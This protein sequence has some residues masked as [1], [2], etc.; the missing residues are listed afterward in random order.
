M[1]NPAGAAFVGGGFVAYL[2]LLAVR[3]NPNIN[4]IAVASRTQEMAEHRARIFAAEP[5]T[6]KNLATLLKR[7]D[8]DIVF[9]L[10][11]NALHAKHALMA[12]RA[13]KHVIIEKPMTVTLA[14]AD[15]VIAA[16][17]KAG[18]LVGY[19]E[20]QVFAPLLMKMK[21]LIADGAIGKVTA[22]SG[23]CGHEGPSPTGWFRMPKFSGGGAHMDLGSHTLE[24]LLYVLGKPAVK[25]VKSCTM[26]E[27]PEGGIDGKAKAILE[28]ENGIELK[29][30][31][32]WLETVD[33]FS[34]EV[35]G[36]DGRITAVFNP[37]PQFLTLHRA[38]GE[39]ENIEFSGQFDMRLNKYLAGS[40]YIGQVAHFQQ[41]FRNGD[42]PTE[43]AVDGRN[44]LRILMAGYL[45]A[46]RNRPV[47]L[48]SKIPM[49]TMPVQLW[50]GEQ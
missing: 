13:G 22:A 16:A 12:I 15:K 31:S 23:I 47:K 34:Y 1:N 25:T 2:H 33:N 41:C 48:S 39:I 8:V 32:S 44:V 40:G 42:V 43:S 50:L 20:N 24:S 36:T 45:C 9:V 49:D 26:T 19:A 17:E 35:E 6:F 3:D 46:G 29:M 14:E 10:S 38:N 27:T 28:T 5:Y 30:M 21:E 37:P 4:L 18:V 11:P 7:K